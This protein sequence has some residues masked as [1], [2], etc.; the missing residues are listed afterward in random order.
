MIWNGTEYCMALFS[1]LEGIPASE[2]SQ[3]DGQRRN[4]GSVLARLD[5]ALL[6]CDHPVP[7][8]ALLWDMIRAVEIS[9]VA[10]TIQDD[11]LRQTVRGV[12]DD[13]ETRA[14]PVLNSLPHQ[15]IHNDFHAGNVLVDS[16]DQSVATGI[17]DF[18]D[19]VK[20]PRIIDLAV[21]VARHASG[22]NPIED[23]AQIVMAYHAQSPLLLPEVEILYDLACTRLAMR[24]AIWSWRLDRDDP[25]VD[26]KIIRHAA[27]WLAMLQQTGRDAACRVFRNV[28]AL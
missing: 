12:F 7:P 23:G 18:G 14:L 26:V 9:P 24:I 10:N 16:R 1:F 28:C 13:F 5:K 25:R 3:T 2:T 27:D 19:I 11:H 21:A 20:A 22:K 6:S 4:I 15:L 8:G 17:I